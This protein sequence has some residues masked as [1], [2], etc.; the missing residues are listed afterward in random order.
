MIK[1]VITIEYEGFL[2]NQDLGKLLMIAASYDNFK[3]L[4]VKDG[5]GKATYSCKKEKE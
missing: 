5:G 1:T 3:Y 4:E 2:S